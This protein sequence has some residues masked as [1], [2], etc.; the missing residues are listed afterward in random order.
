MKRCEKQAHRLRFP[1]RLD[2]RHVFCSADSAR[3]DAVSDTSADFDDVRM[4]FAES[5]CQLDRAG[6]STLKVEHRNELTRRQ[7]EDDQLMI[8]TPARAMS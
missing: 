3:R 6:I 4:R 5:G 1:Y 8:L 7:V 2:G